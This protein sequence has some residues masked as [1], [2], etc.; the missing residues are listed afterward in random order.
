MLKETDW[1]TTTIGVQHFGYKL[2]PHGAM[3]LLAV[4]NCALACN[5]SCK[6]NLVTIIQL[7]SLN[8]LLSCPTSP[9]EPWDFPRNSDSVARRGRARVLCSS[10]A[11]INNLS[12]R[13]GLQQARGARL[14]FM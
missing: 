6:V 2:V 4:L 10:N 13:D 1:C 8:T 5:G 12:V 7:P 14:L 3:A 9:A 11:S